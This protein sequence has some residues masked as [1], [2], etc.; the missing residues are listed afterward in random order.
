LTSFADLLHATANSE[1]EL[2]RT[3]AAEFGI[4]PAELANEEPGAATRAYTDFLVRT[5]ATGDFAEVCAALLPCMW[6]FAD[7]GTAL[8]AR[9]L[10]A[11]P[12]YVRWIEMYADPD[13]AELGQWCRDLVDSLASV[14]GLQTR[15]RMRDAF[16]TSARYELAFWD[17]AW[18]GTSNRGLRIVDDG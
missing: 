2:H 5:A 15:Q 14:A 11:D 8:Q 3:Y 13:F 6:A 17:M 9:S 1:M 10:P 7:I 16:L 12:R 4:T 18:E